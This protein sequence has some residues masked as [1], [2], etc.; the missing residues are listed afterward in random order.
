MHIDHNA[1][2]STLS[3]R[4]FIITFWGSAFSNPTSFFSAPLCPHFLLCAPLSHHLLGSAFS[5]PTS[6]RVHLWALANIFS[7]QVTHYNATNSPCFFYLGRSPI[8]MRS[9]FHLRRSPITMRPLFPFYLGRS[10]ITIRPK[11]FWVG[12]PLQLDHSWLVLKSAFL[13]RFYIIILH[14]KYQ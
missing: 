5:N 2:V 4:C 3:D 11:F 6:F 1:L 9:F 14:L 8:T 13:S 10:P 12:H 7:G